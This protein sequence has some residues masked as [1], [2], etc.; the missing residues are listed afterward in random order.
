MTLNRKKFDPEFKRKAVELFMNSNKPA[1]EIAEELGISAE[2][3]YK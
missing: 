1:P 3:L 2:S